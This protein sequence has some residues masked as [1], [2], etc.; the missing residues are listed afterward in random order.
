[1]RKIILFCFSVFFFSCTENKNLTSVR[2]VTFDITNDVF[3]EGF[4]DSKE[5]FLYYSANNDKLYKF[6]LNTLKT[7]SIDLSEKFKFKNLDRHSIIFNEEN[8]VVYLSR[9]FQMYNSE[10]S[11]IYKLDSLSGYNGMEYAIAF[12]NSN[13]WNDNEILLANLFTCDLYNKPTYDIKQTIIDC[14]QLNKK[15]PSYSI[16]DFENN[17]F[18]LSTIN[19]STI[20]ADTKN[21]TIEPWYKATATFVGKVVLYNN[22][23]TNGVF[24]IDKAGKVRRAFT[25]ESKYTDFQNTEIF[26]GTEMPNQIKNIINYS[27]QVN[28]M[29]YDE[30]RNK[31]LV[32]VVHGTKDVE[33]NGEKKLS[34][35]PFSILVYNKDYELENEY[36]FDSL[37]HDFNN[38]Y[39][40]KEGL[41]INANN[42]LG[43]NYKPEKLIY[44]IF[45]Y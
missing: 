44:E 23:F 3:T 2:T 40:C 22:H 20:K 6:Y 13:S 43:N 1:M 9:Y 35:R 31:I 21:N 14:E 27:T 10:T 19:F 16:L 42:K 7:D 41:I 30:Y 37:K 17:K 12:N 11:K 24:E 45:S 26:K 8:Y 28:G 25:L 38:I 29:L 5:P 15:K 36:L 32:I 34:N 18:E 4:S 39:V 33:K